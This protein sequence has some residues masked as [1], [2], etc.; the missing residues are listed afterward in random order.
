MNEDD[1]QMVDNESE[2]PLLSWILGDRLSRH[3]YVWV[4]VLLMV[5]DSF[6][7]MALFIPYSYIQP[8]AA[9]VKIPSNLT[10]LLISA[11]GLG[12]ITGWELDRIC[13]N[14]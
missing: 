5:A 10:S 6:A 2:R 11:I 8:V 14:L 4:F 3:Q 7:V 13:S 9:I 1:L 12:S